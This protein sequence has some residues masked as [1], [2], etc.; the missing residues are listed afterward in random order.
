MNPSSSF[1]VQ[2]KLKYDSK[3]QLLTSEASINKLLKI[4]V[5]DT[6]LASDFSQDW[7]FNRYTELRSLNST[8]LKQFLPYI[9]TT[10]ITADSSL[11]TPATQRRFWLA[12]GTTT[13]Q[14]IGDS[15]GYPD[16]IS[17]DAIAQTDLLVYHLPGEEWESAKALAPQ[18][19][20]SGSGNEYF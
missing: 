11:A 18:L 2:A 15:W 10:K 8:T 1:R 19:F 17:P 9:I 14:L 6:N 5:G 12:D 7:I 4:V 20:A 3:Q 16:E 13:L